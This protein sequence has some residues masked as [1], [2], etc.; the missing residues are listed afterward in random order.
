MKS[1]QH[2]HVNRIE[3]ASLSVQNRGFL[4]RPPY[5][6]RSRARVGYHRTKVKPLPRCDDADATHTAIEL[7]ERKQL[8]VREVVLR[9]LSEEGTRQP[10]AGVAG[11]P[12]ATA[13][14]VAVYGVVSTISGNGPCPFRHF[15]DRPR[16]MA[17][18]N[19]WLSSLYLPRLPPHAT[20]LGEHAA[21]T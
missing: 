18:K 19:R 17:A 5:A 1:A 12:V 3:R 13:V 15:N 21:Y 7:V 14:C 10:F 9:Y 11:I 20:R 4:R 8:R 2:Y 6:T 16:I